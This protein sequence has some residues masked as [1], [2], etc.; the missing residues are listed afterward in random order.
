MDVVGGYVVTV[1]YPGQPPRRVEGYT[2]R[3]SAAHAAALLAVTARPDGKRPVV[4]GVA[5]MPD[6]APPVHPGPGS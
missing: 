4:V 5:E 3:R 6:P 1:K 2:T